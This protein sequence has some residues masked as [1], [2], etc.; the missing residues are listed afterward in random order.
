VPMLPLASWATA[1]GLLGMAR[2]PQS[3]GGS[4]VAL[5]YSGVIVLDG[6]VRGCEGDITSSVAQLSNIKEG[7]GH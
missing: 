3:S 6:G 1:T 5:K 2:V 7:M 4:L